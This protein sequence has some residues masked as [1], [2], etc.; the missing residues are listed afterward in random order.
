[1]TE[2]MLD[3]GVYCGCYIYDGELVTEPKEC[4]YTDTVK[5]DLEDWCIELARVVCP[6]C[7]AELHQMNNHFSLCDKQTV[8]VADMIEAYS[9]LMENC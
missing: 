5:V 4:A 1:M 7:G 8:S 9:E 2:I 6:N 3:V